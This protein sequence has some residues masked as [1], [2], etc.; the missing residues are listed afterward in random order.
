MIHPARTIPYNE[1]YEKLQSEVFEGRVYEH[2][3]SGE[4]SDL[5]LYCYSDECVYERKWNDINVLARGLILDVVKKEV[6]ATPFPKFFNYGEHNDNGRTGLPAIPDLPFET[7]EKLDGS[8]IIIF[9]H[10]GRW[11]C[12]TKGSLSSDQAQ[13]AEAFL[14]KHVVSL[15]PG[16]TYLCEGIY[17]ANRIVVDYRD[18]EALR[19]LAIYNEDGSEVIHDELPIWMCGGIATPYPYDSISELLERAKELSGNEEG[20]VLRFSNGLRL[21]IK[22]EE[23]CR[24]HRMVANLTPLNVWH[25]MRDGENLEEIRKGL[26]EE[27]WKDFDTI[28][29]LLESR[30]DEL[31]TRVHF[32]GLPLKE[33]SDKEVGLRLHEFPAD[34]RRFIFPARKGSLLEGRIRHAIFEEIRPDRNI[35]SGYRASASVT[36][37]QE[38]E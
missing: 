7:F 6:V 28:V 20:Y 13:W 18:Q 34:I 32:T 29:N 21:K 4:N 22:G 16:K 35:L 2:V 27:F 19:L 17:P 26:P 24:I 14:Q 12:S 36:R 8:L 38:G 15:I 37:A 10:N 11:K 23:Y 25:Q 5:H 30:L 33:L 31:I 3:G 1:L 9:F